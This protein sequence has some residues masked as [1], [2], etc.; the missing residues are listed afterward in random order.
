M[1]IENNP[2]PQDTRVRAE[3][4]ALLSFGCR[5]SVICPSGKHQP[6]RESVDGVDVYRFRAPFE[7]HGF[8]GYAWEY[9]YS[10][11]IMFA[12]SVS[13]W[14]RARFQVIH[15]ANPSDTLVLIAAVYKLFGTKFVFDHH[16]LSPELYDANCGGKG[17]G[18]VRTVLALFEKLSFYLADAV[19]ATNESYL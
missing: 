16:D 13:V 15:A 10:T 19:I 2:Y 17:N 1:L 11:M 4:S 12:I 3:A 5:V 7:A 6:A 18:L 8:W 9:L 14:H